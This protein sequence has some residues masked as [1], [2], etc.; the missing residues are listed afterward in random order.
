M[1]RE[2]TKTRTAQTPDFKSQKTELEEPA[3][4]E[5]EGLSGDQT[6]RG[7][8]KLTVSDTWKATGDL[9]RECDVILL[10]VCETREKEREI[11]WLNEELLQNGKDLD[12]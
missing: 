2:G 1:K 11:K 5:R 9:C 7:I 3:D 10:C 6:K 8:V 12:L 4:L